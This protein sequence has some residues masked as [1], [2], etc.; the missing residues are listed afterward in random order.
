VRKKLTI[1]VGLGSI[2]LIV[3]AITIFQKELM[4]QYH[5]FRLRND[6][7]YLQSI[8]SKPEGTSQRSAV[9]QY[10]DIPEGRTALL[11]E[12]LRYVKEEELRS[13]AVSEKTHTYVLEL[14]RPL[15]SLQYLR[16]RRNQEH[17]DLPVPGAQDRRLQDSK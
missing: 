13:I 8:L 5:L 14:P 10:L 9:R 12:L 17:I 11:R 7:S 15:P 3:L 4:T 2:A 16:S 1:F 6:S